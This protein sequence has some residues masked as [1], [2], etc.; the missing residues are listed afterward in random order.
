MIDKNA[1]LEKNQMRTFI[2]I[3]LKIV[4]VCRNK[5]GSLYIKQVVGG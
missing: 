4:C 5:T 1:N 3:V 2:C